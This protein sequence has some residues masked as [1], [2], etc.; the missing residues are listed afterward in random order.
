ML[1]VF[2]CKK[3]HVICVCSCY[4]CLFVRRLMLF[5]FVCKKAHVICVCL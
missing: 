5:V 2:V 1:F 4:L 3:A